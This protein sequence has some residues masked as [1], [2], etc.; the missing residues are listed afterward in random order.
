MPPSTTPSRTML[1]YR[2]G[3]ISRK[4]SG[5]GDQGENF[6]AAGGCSGGV[7]SSIALDA[8]VVTKFYAAASGCGARLSRMKRSAIG[9]GYCR[10]ARLRSATPALGTL[11]SIADDARR[12]HVVVQVECCDASRLAA[13]ALALVLSSPAN[14][15]RV[16]KKQ[17]S[18]HSQQVAANANARRVKAQ[19]SNAVYWGCC[20]KMGADPD[21]FIRSQIP[22]DA[23]RFFGGL[24]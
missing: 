17:G 14:A 2:R 10:Q 18:Y 12:H 9:A 1:V 11:R 8:L 7:G 19:D 3:L 5:C 22:R 23:S 15:E 20:T 16:T 6:L 21:P 24:D 13:A 4:Q